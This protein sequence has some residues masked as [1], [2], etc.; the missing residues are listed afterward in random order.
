RAGESY[1]V[2]G[3]NNGFEASLD[4]SDLNGSNGFVI[5][6]IDNF[7][8]SGFSVSSAR[9]INGDG[10]D[11]IIIG[12][13]GGDPNGNDRAG[14]SYVVFGRNNGFEASL[15]LADLDGS[16]GF[17]INGT[18]AIDYSGRSVSGAGDINGDGFDDLI[19]GTYR[20]DPNGNDRAGESY[21]VFGR[22][23]G[24]EASLDLSDLNGS[25]GFVINGIDNFDSSGR[26][27]SGAGDINGDG[28]D[29]LIIGAPGGDPNGNDRAGESYV[30][31]GFSTGSTTNTPPNAVADE[32]TTAQNTEL[33]V[34]VDDLLANDRDPDGDLLT[35]E[36]VDN[37]VNGTVGLDDRGNISF[38][39]DPDFVGT[40]RFEYTISDGKGETDT[41][42]VTIT[43][44]SAGEV[45][46]IIGTP[47]PDELVG[48]PDNDTIQGL[49]GED[50]LAGNEGN[51]LIDGGEGND[52]LRGDQNS[53]ATGGIAGGDDTITGGAG[54]DRIGGK[55]GNDQLFG[56]EGNDRIWGDGGDDL[57]DGGLGNDRLYGDSGNISGGFDTFVLAEGGGTDTIFDFEVGI[58]SLG[59]ATGLTVEELTIST[60]GNNTE[61]VLNGEVLAILKDVR[62]EDPTLLGFSLV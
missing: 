53:R 55:G 4:L 5:N 19:I 18:D 51:D 28:F 13:T 10:F 35:V 52:L 31:F 23:N 54:N 34:T 59:L 39:P 47:D 45:S 24:F 16:N 38:I 2:F 32:F 22:N 46:D 43:V 60:V 62:V 56:N 27:V 15:D 11:D 6:G 50:T 58:D 21:V 30:V 36:S 48:T 44:D 12:A 37:A 3:R 26:S 29:D 25:N 1:V 40:A 33:T 49:A 8:S 20:A 7:D 61:I 42:T 57:I 14:E 9:D 41:A 17:V